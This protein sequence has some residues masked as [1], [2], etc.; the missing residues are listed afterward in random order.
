MTWIYLR[1]TQILLPSTCRRHVGIFG[2]T[3]M[4]LKNLIFPHLGDW[5]IHVSRNVLYWR[6][7]SDGQESWYGCAVRLVPMYLTKGKLAGLGFLSDKQSIII[8]LFFWRQLES[9]FSKLFHVAL[10][11]WR[12]LFFDLAFL[13]VINKAIVPI[14]RFLL[15]CLL[16]FKEFD[17][18][19]SILIPKVEVSVSLLNS[20]SWCDSLTLI[21]EFYLLLLCI[22]TCLRLF[23]H[24][25]WNLNPPIF[26]GGLFSLRVFLMKNWYFGES[27]FSV[28]SSCSKRHVYLT[29]YRD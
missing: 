12:W 7:H 9:F 6:D 4:I 14:T 13:K 1:F 11:L 5:S 18:R 2:N 28:C 15:S 23:R 16:F 27:L 17:T 19:L 22:V 8:F 24:N 25:F 26:V 29:L 21:Y 3:W 20:E 10:V